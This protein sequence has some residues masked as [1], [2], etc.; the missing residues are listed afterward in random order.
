MSCG[1]DGATRGGFGPGLRLADPPVS[2]WSISGTCVALAAPSGGRGIAVHI[3]V[4]SEVL[5]LIFLGEWLPSWEEGV[6]A[7]EVD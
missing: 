4:W 7:L 6:T 3:S 1:Q 2:R 5:R